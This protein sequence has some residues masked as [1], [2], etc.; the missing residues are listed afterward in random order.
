MS[1][2]GYVLAGVGAAGI[3]VGFYIP[4]H[5]V[6]DFERKKMAAEYNRQLA[7]ELGLNSETSK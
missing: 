5:P 6:K 2:A 7:V 1:T 4:V 3:G